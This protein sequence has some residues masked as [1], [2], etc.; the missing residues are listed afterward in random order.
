MK[1]KYPQYAPCLAVIQVGERED[2]TVYVGM[3][4]KAAQAAGIEFI[5]KKIPEDVTQLE[6]IKQ[7]KQLN[8]DDKVHGILVQM[9]LPA[10]IDESA[11]LEAIDP[12]K[13]VD[14]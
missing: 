8:D 2:S 4:Q 5:Y 1:S 14:G 3:K 12:K 10:H 7:V 9:P 11:V 13:D 6:L